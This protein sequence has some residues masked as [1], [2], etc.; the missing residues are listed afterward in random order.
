MSQIFEHH[1][2]FLEEC[3][4]AFNENLLLETFS[5][6]DGTLIG[7]RYGAD[8]DC[9]KII[10]LGQEVAL[11]A[12]AIDKTDPEEHISALSNKYDY[13]LREVRHEIGLFSEEME[14]QLKA[15]D[16]RG[17]WHDCTN[18]YLF[19]QMSRHYARIRNRSVSH[20]EFQRRCVNIANYAMMLF[21][22]DAR[23][24]VRGS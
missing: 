10:E 3:K 14:K 7:L 15:N 20:S 22:N 17:G 4:K 13:D 5:N 21:D 11:F 9:V 8:R 23:K 18:E 24:Q 19:H 2:E 16:H 1:L 6:E 12:Q